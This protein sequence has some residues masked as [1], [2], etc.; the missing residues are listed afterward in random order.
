MPLPVP[1]L[2]RSALPHVWWVRV[3]HSLLGGCDGSHITC[4]MS[5]VWIPLA[6]SC[7][8]NSSHHT[9]TSTPHI[10]TS[11]CHLHTSHLHI[12]PSPSP[13]PSPPPPGLKRVTLIKDPTKGIGCTIK[14]AAGHIL[15]NRII[16][17]GPIAHT[18]VLRPG[19]GRGL[20]SGFIF[21]M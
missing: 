7:Q 6:R 5:A 2:S 11:R 15:V 19:R 8:I 21:S 16:E 18:G 1:C 20:G 14:A 10:F 17:D 3:C 9:I 12:T 13:S 4:H